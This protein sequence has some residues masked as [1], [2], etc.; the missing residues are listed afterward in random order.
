MCASADA[1]VLLVVASVGAVLLALAGGGAVL[2]CLPFAVP[3]FFL[4]RAAR[5]AVRF[6]RGQE[7]LPSVVDTA[8]GERSWRD[9]E[10]A[11]VAAGFGKAL[12][13]SRHA[14]T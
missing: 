11:A 8:S 5:S 10:R 14:T 13:R 1:L 12:L 4:A 2:M 3:G 6:H 7:P 9:A